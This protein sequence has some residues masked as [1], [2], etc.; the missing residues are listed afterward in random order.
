MRDRADERP[1]T[2]PAADTLPK[3]LA[4]NAA[5]HPDE[6]ALREKEF[7]IWRSYTWAE[8]EGRVRTRA[9]GLAAIGVKRGQVVGLIGD[10]RPDWVFGELAAHALGALSMG[11][12]R[13][14]LDEEVA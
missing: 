10:N 1:H 14:A 4:R 13:G 2:G 3:L 9:L 11:I 8:Y 12:Y 5:A 7:G 6:V